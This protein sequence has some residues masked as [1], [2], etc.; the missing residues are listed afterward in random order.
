MTKVRS[1]SMVGT[2]K[3]VLMKHPKQAYGSQTEITHQWESLNYNGPPDLSKAF[4]DY[5]RFLALITENG[6]SVE[7]LPHSEDTGLDSIYTH[8]PVVVTNGGIILCNMGK[9]ARKSEPGAMGK[10]F[11]DQDLPILGRITPPGTLEGGDIV[12]IDEN[13]VAVGEGYRTNSE[14][15]QQ[16]REL[17]GDSVDDVIPVPLPHWTGPTDCLHLLSNVSPVDHDLYVVYSPLITVPFRSYLLK[18][19]IQLIEVPE[20]EYSTLGCNILALAPR[21]V[22][23]VDG[24]PKV[25]STLEKTG[26]EVFVF[27][28][29]EICLKGAGGPTCLTRPIY[30]S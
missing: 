18:R 20:E 6:S 21:K 26:V 29:S 12:W 16:F 24:N 4:S 10:Y 8:D 14:G 7:F 13:T 3:I 15:I 23:M 28:G 22:I 9:M 17:L 1:Q 27:D 2:L 19:G 11:H 30:R 5:D 25:R